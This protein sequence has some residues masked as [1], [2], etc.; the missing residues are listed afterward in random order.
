[1]KRSEI[2]TL[3]TLGAIALVLVLLYSFVFAPMLFEEQEPYVPE[4]REG[5]GLYLNA[6]VSLYPEINSTDIKEIDVINEHGEYGF[7]MKEDAKGN[8]EMVIKGYESLRYTE[9]VFA[10][11][12]SYTRLPIV[13]KDTNIYRD[14]DSAKM[15]EYGLTEDTCQAK[16]T[17][18]YTRDGKE[19]SQTVLIGNKIM[20]S[21]SLFYVTVEGRNH[22]YTMNGAGVED[23]ILKPLSSYINPAI[24][25]NFSSASA[26]VLAI[27][28]FGLYLTKPNDD[29]LKTVLML[30]KDKTQSGETG[31]VYYLTCEKIYPQK[32]I[33]S[34]TYITNAFGQLFTTFVGDE[35]VAIVPS[36]PKKPIRIDAEYKDMTDEE[37]AK[38]LADYEIEYASANEKRQAVLGEYGLNSSQEHFQIYAKGEGEGYI[39]LQISKQNDDCFYVLSE[40]YDTHTIVKVKAEALSFIGEGE[41]T[42]IKWTATNSVYAGFSDYLVSSDKTIPTV[43]TIRIKT[44]ANG[45]SYGG[46]DV[47]FKVQDS[48]YGGYLIQSLDGQYSFDT[49]NNSPEKI[50]LFSTLYTVLIVMP[51]PQHFTTLTD[52]QKAEIEVEENLLYELEVVLSNDVCKKYSYYFINSGYALCVT[53]LGSLKSVDGQ[54]TVVYDRKESVFET[55]VSHIT[56]VA[57]AYEKTLKGEYYIQNDFIG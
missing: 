55:S 16:F 54:S 23:A 52:E 36:L 49:S 48:P 12:A 19:E 28:N 35:V 15:A 31:A 3:S 6:F 26:A 13:P 17:I 21:K 44:K 2:I 14:V 1:M 51:K 22:V 41:E 56:S 5:E 20:S 7:Y 34:S 47:T 18:K 11:L 45:I 24:Y 43:Y 46:Y 39:T 9:L 53:R 32:V 40:Y 8:K 37:F 50:D 25:N 38:A 57:R 10:Y 29:T 42:A 4:I 27:N 33:A 30:D